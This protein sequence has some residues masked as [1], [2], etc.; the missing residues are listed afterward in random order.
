MKKFSSLKNIVFLHHK[1]WDLGSN[2]DLVNVVLGE[3]MWGKGGGG[4]QTNTRMSA[5]GAGFY[6]YRGGNKSILRESGASS[7]L[8][9]S[10]EDITAQTAQTC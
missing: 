1:G 4:G 3:W 2:A 10:T 5:M 6:G 7:L 9:L 8:L